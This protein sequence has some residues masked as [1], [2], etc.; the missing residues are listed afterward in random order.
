[1][2][3]KMLWRERVG[4]PM[5]VVKLRSKFNAEASEQ[6]DAPAGIMNLQST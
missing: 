2:V 5:I 1:M 6:Q 4:D 3:K